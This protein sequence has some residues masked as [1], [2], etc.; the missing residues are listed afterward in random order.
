MATLIQMRDLV[1]SIFVQI[2]GEDVLLY[3]DDVTG[4]H[5]RAA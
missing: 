1:G 5:R 3:V 2:G 4:E